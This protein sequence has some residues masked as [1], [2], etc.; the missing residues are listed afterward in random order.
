MPPIFKLACRSNAYLPDR[1]QQQENAPVKIHVRT[2]RVWHMQSSSCI[3]VAGI[4]SAAASLLIPWRSSIR[5]PLMVCI[6]SCAGTSFS[7][8]P[9]FVRSTASYVC[10]ERR[11]GSRGGA[12]P[13]C[14]DAPTTFTAKAN[15]NAARRPATLVFQIKS[16]APPPSFI[17]PAPRS[18][19]NSDDLHR[20]IYLTKSGWGLVGC[21]ER[22]DPDHGFMAFP[23]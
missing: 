13:A 8:S 15:E 12:Y 6:A 9:L 16:M 4:A 17:K 20:G 23:L 10:S 7:R 3:P 18:L 2:S 11:T 22:V 21:P 1:D 19:G 5:L 14:S